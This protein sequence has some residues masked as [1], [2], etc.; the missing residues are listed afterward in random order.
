MCTT[1]KTKSSVL[2][3]YVQKLIKYGICVAREHNGK[4]DGNSY[5][6][7]TKIIQQG[8]DHGILHL[9]LLRLQI[10]FTDLLWI[11]C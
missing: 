10:M 8:A 7:I 4:W 9:Q 2:H 3:T 5:N 1:N 11:I 6:L